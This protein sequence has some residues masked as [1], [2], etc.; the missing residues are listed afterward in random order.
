MN[1]NADLGR[2]DKRDFV[3]SVRTTEIS[4]YMKRAHSHRHYEI[5]NIRQNNSAEQYVEV[6]NSR[7]HF[8]DNTFMLFAPHVK[9]KFVYE[10]SHSTR[11]LVNISTTLA[12]Q[13]SA[14]LNIDLDSFFSKTAVEFTSAQTRELYSIVSGFTMMDE[15]D[16]VS[17]DASVRRAKVT[18]AQFFEHMLF[19]NGKTVPKTKTDK[20]IERILN[21]I[22]VNYN[23]A[24]TLDYLSQY[25]L[26]NKYDF[27]RQIREYTGLTFSKYLTQVRINAACE[28]LETTN[29]SIIDISY[30]VGFNSASYFSVVFKQHKNISPNDYRAM[31]R[32][33]NTDIK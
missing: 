9:H 3:I 4:S 28:L 15:N 31:H 7:I 17:A 6:E 14:Y 29:S 32:L 18:L 8:S 30:R 5:I 24:I 26:L 22:D 21:Y 13:I 20:K 16:F 10:R 2:D 27:C 33:E 1:K 19:Y 23:E 11:L 25:F 12:E